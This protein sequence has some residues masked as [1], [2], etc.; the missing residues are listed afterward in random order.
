MEEIRP[1]TDFLSSLAQINRTDYQI[2]GIK[3]EMIFSTGNASWKELSTDELQDFTNRI[4]GLENFQYTASDNRHYLC[5]VP[6]KNGQ[7]VFGALIALGSG[8]DNASS[9][10]GEQDPDTSHAGEMEG[11]LRHLVTLMNEHRVVEDEMEDMAQELE[12]NFE[13]LNLYSAVA[14]KLRKLKFSKTMLAN[15]ME[16]LLGSMRSDMAF[17]LFPYRPQY[18]VITSTEPASGHVDDQQEFV[19]NLLKRIPQDSPTLE[20]KYF[21]VNDSREDAQYRD[22]A[23]T[24]YRFLAVKVKHDRDFYGWLGLVSFNLEEIFRQGELKLLLSMSEQLAIMIAN[25]DLYEDLEEFLINM[26]KSLV[27]AIEAKDAYTRG[28]SERVARY[29]QLMGKRLGLSERE[30]CDLKWASILHDIGKIA[31]PEGILNKPDRLTKAEYEIVKEHSS[32]GGEIL[33]PVKQLLNSLPAIIHHH[34]RYDGQGYPMGLEGEGIPLSARII[35][36]ADTFD[37]INST[38]AY[39]DAKSLGET[40]EIMEEVAGSQLDPNLV[41]VFKEMCHEGLISGREKGHGK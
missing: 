20:E 17:V 33:R 7:G 39:R 28:H 30:S 13:A 10:K 40:L 41:R 9:P 37:A 21:I 18:N 23:H 32:K 16:E 29:S 2:R 27:F 36:V 19:H 35:S 24:P 11:F 8:P 1:F 3:G 25:A 4:I 26:V 38:R 6:L 5:G 22:L 14:A 34:E 15:L 31:I 12:S